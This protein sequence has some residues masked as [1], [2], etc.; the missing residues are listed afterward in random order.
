LGD[1]SGASH[2]SQAFFSSKRWKQ[3]RRHQFVLR[4]CKGHDFVGLQETHSTKGRASAFVPEQGTTV[5]WSHDGRVTAGI[6]LLVKTSFLGKFACHEW[7]EIEQ[8]RVGRLKLRGALGS[9]D[10]WVVY[11]S[12]TDPAARTDSIRKMASHMMPADRALSCVF[13]DVNSTLNER[14]RFCQQSGKWTGRN[15]VSNRNAWLNEMAKPFNSHEWEQ[16]EHTHENGIVRSRLDRFYTNEH[17]SHQLQNTCECVALPFPLGLSAP[18][19]GTSATDRFHSRGLSI[20]FFQ[21]GSN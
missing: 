12:A 19:G 10:L 2:N 5:S 16:H 9:L 13:G 15:D 1:S 4:L 18:G 7:E 8:G 20:V 14:D 17:V 11:S 3:E 6:G 21:K